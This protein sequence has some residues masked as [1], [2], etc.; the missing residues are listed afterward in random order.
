MTTSGSPSLTTSPASTTTST[1][2][3]AEVAS[4]EPIGYVPGEVPDGVSCS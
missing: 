1:T 2:V 3:P 4:S